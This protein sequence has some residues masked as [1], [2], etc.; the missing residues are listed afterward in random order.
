MKQ[1]GHDERQRKEAYLSADEQQQ[2][3]PL[4]PRDLSIPDARN[5]NVVK[6]VVEMPLDRDQSVQRP[7]VDALQPMEFEARLMRR[8]PAEKADVD[9][10]VKACDVRVRMMNGV[11][12]PCPDVRASAGQV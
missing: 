10:V 4:R 9:V 3:F 7:H 1:H 8:E 6:V 12:L 11:V 5:R 2:I